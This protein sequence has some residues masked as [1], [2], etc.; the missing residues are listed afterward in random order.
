MNDKIKGEIVIVPVA[1]PIGLDQEMMGQTVGRFDMSTGINFNR[2]YQ[3]L[4]QRL[5]TNVSGKLN[6][7][8]EHNKQL[9]RE[10]ALTILAI[11]QPS[12]A[13]SSM[14]K[15]LQTL[16]I[17]AD[18]VLD[19]HCD[20]QAV[21]HLYTGTPLADKTM[22]LARYLGAKAMLLSMHSGD[23][24]FDESCSKHWWELAN[25][26]GEQYPIPYACQAVTVELRGEVDVS[27]DYAEQDA[28]AI[29]QFLIDQNHI[30]G[31]QIEMPP[32]Q[33]KSTPLEGSEPIIATHSGLIVFLK[34]IGEIV[35][36]GDVIAELIDPISGVITPLKTSVSGVMYARVAKRY[37]HH[38]VSIAKIAGEVAY[39]TG[40]LLSM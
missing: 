15:I 28:N 39:R 12:N 2:G 31:A 1:N 10:Q 23:D 33:C 11:D 24:P 32:A 18:I 21:L 38:G 19:L 29:I 36:A 14:K 6:Q 37:V 30:E 26:F 3:N 20:N 17:D 22:P 25:H 40:N 35:K 16:A 34:D 7:D 13:T 27:H 5:I 8:A 4:T 9:I